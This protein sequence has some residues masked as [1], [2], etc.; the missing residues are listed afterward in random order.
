MQKVEEENGVVFSIE[1]MSDFYAFIDH[2]G[3]ILLS[4]KTRLF[5]DSYAGL[6][7]GCGCT[8][9]ARAKRVEALYL[10]VPNSLD[11]HRK[12]L[13][14]KVLSEGQEKPAKKIIF[15]HNNDKFHEIEF[16]VPE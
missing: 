12:F 14:H 7:K 10:E 1:N 4:E 8:R 13:L 5:M 6:G 15:R 16:V 9:A 11:D 2:K 3:L